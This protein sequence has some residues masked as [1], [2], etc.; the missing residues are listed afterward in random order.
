[1][2]TF[3]GFVLTSICQGVETTQRVLVS[4]VPSSGFVIL[5]M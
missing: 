4:F 2:E 1:M 5:E 3:R